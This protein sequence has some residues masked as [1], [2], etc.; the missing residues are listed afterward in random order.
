MARISVKV[1]L[2][3]RRRHDRG[4]RGQ[5]L[6]TDLVHPSP[7]MR[8]RHRRLAVNSIHHAGEAWRSGLAETHQEL[9]M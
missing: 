8:L 4:R 5:G 2:R 9:W 6:L 7:A 1:V 3:D